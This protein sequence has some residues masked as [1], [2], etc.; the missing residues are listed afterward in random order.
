MP[1]LRASRLVCPTLRRPITDVVYEQLQSPLTL[2]LTFESKLK[3]NVGTEGNDAAICSEGVERFQQYGEKAPSSEEEFKV[4]KLMMKYVT[5]TTYDAVDKYKDTDNEPAAY[6]NHC[7]K[8]GIQ[9]TSTYFDEASTPSIEGDS[10]TTMCGVLS[11]SFESYYQD[12]NTNAD[13]GGNVQL[14]VE[15]S[16]PSSPPASVDKDPHLHFA[17]G[18][19]ADFRGKHGQMYAFFSAPGLA[20]NVKTEDNPVLHE[21]LAPLADSSPPF[22]SE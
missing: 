6:V 11:P 21:R 5:T 7:C 1:H 2:Y 9:G 12:G 8:A 20:V 3:Q 18:G 10:C 4:Q 13:A 22:L 16:P 14:W 15:P 19:R 17:H